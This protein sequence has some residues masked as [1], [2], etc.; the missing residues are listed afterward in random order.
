MVENR[1]AHV[2][3]VSSNQ[4]SLRTLGK[5][6]PSRTVDCVTL[7]DASSASAQQ[8]VANRLG[9]EVAKD[10]KMK[11]VLD[12]LGGRLTDLELLVQKIRAGSSIQGAFQDILFRNLSEIRK[13]GFGDDMV[14]AKSLGWSIPALWTLIEKLADKGEVK[15]SHLIKNHLSLFRFS[16]IYILISPSPSPSPSPS[17]SPPYKA[18]YDEIRFSS[19]FKGEESALLAMESANL[20][21]IVHRNGKMTSWKR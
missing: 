14:D 7:S 10:P 19:F 15:G 5:A 2:I 13:N 16:R 20:I 21:F 3:F 11:V 6:L 4:S 12:L 8:L 1:I 9:L 18:G 17:S